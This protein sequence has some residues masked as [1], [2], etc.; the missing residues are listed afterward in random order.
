MHALQTM[1]VV[2]ALAVGL[3]AKLFVFPTTKAEVERDPIQTASLSGPQLNLTSSYPN[4]LPVETIH[5]M[6]FVD[7]ER[8][9]R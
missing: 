8:I 7:P 1:A 6:T 3:G 4:G 2:A 9:D 5:D